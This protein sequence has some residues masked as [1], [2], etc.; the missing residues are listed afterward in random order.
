[1]DCSIPFA[2]ARCLQF[3]N[4]FAP[5]EECFANAVLLPAD[6]TPERPRVDGVLIHRPNAWDESSHAVRLHELIPPK[7]KGKSLWS[8]GTDLMKHLKEKMGFNE[9]DCFFVG[10]VDG[11][12]VLELIGSCKVNARGGVV[13]RLE[14][15]IMRGLQSNSPL[16]V[17]LIPEPLASFTMSQSRPVRFY[18]C[19]L[20]SCID[21]GANKQDGDSV[22]VLDWMPEH[23]PTLQLVEP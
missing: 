16:N 13:Y 15:V 7:D 14:N 2:E 3:S 17:P 22:A 18:V 12:I 4:G 19:A 23:L 5:E 1:V 11:G 8:V 21:E 20:P 10:D 9:D 6:A